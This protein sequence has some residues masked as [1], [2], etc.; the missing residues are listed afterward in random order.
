MTESGENFD[1]P[2]VL[3]ELDDLKGQ[4]ERKEILLLAMVIITKEGERTILT[5]IDGLI[6]LESC[7]EATDALYGAISGFPRTRI[8]DTEN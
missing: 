1:T 4:F 6:P 8:D 7:K 3:A 5:T 2:T